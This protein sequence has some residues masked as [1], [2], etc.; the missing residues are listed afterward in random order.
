MIN[1][2]D[3][4]TIA[5]VGLLTGITLILGFTYLGFIPLPTPAGAATIM[6]IPVIISGIVL[7]PGFG[8]LIG[9]LFGLSTVYY[10]SSIAPFWVLIPAR[11]LIGVVAGI[12]FSFLYKILSIKSKIRVLTNFLFSIIV[13]SLLFL[14]GNNIFQNLFPQ[15]YIDFPIESSFII[16]LLS[17]IIALPIYLIFKEKKPEII[18]LSIASLLGSLTNTVGTLGLAVI[19]GIFPLGTAI[20]VGVI[21]GIP[22]AILAVI[23]CVP[24]SIALRRYLQKEER[25]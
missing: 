25:Y 10:F 1:L 13:F 6:H 21:H 2:K 8:A 17:F 24:T 14:I 20:S 22:E 11:P 7:G 12:T 5:L 18:S 19:F 15:R 9:F 4:K 23:I 3:P 16:S